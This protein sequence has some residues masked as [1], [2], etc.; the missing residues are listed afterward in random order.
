MLLEGGVLIVLLL[1]SSLLPVPEEAVLLLGAYFVGSG[2]DAWALG[3]VAVLALVAA[4]FVQY[5]RGRAASAAFTKFRKGQRFI[6]NTGFFAVFMSRFLVSV[7]AVMRYAAGAMRMP[8]VP[9]VIASVLSSLVSVLVIMVGGS[10]V[11]RSLL[12][13]SSSA[14]VI[15]FAFTLV[16]AGVLVV[17]NVK[18]MEKMIP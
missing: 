15:W 18:G 14:N 11:Y 17:Q 9:F 2:S 13:M 4:D 3:L 5:A 1:A 10:W 12:L 6:T 16:V 7:R 8:R